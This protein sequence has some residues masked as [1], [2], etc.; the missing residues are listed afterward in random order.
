M[1]HKFYI[2]AT[3]DLNGIWFGQGL[4]EVLHTNNLTM[5]Q[6]RAMVNLLDS[7]VNVR[8][9]PVYDV[10]Y[11]IATIIS[12]SS[13]ELDLNLQWNG[14]HRFC[15]WYA[16]FNFLFEKIDDDGISYE[17]V[18]RNDEEGNIESLFNFL[19]A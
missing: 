10:L 17:F 5:D 8:P 3:G 11:D 9:Y 4:C 19:V 13:V 16:N 14:V 6:V 12:G 2:G 1:T 15:E 18:Y 7:N